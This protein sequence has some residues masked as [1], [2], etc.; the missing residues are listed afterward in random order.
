MVKLNT[1]LNLVL[2]ALG[3]LLTAAGFLLVP[4]ALDLP[5]RWGIDGHVLATMPR[6]WA[7]LQMPLATA[8]VYGVVF[9]IIT[10]GTAQTRPSTATVLRLAMPTLTVLFILV[11]LVIV[12]SGLG[13]AVPFFQPT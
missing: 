1:P 3:V 7:L 11:Q 4:S 13:I 2:L 9:L 12:L 5:V 6:N 8:L 10:R